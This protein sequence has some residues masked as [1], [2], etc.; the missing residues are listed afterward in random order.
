MS[1]IARFLPGLAVFA[2]VSST[3]SSLLACLVILAVC[4]ISA[5]ETFL[6][7]AF[8][9]LSY[10]S[11]SCTNPVI[12]AFLASVSASIPLRLAVRPV[13][14]KALK[15]S[16]TCLPPPSEFAPR[17]ACLLTASKETALPFS[18]SSVRFILNSD[19]F[20]ESS[21][22]LLS[23]TRVVFANASKLFFN[24]IAL[25]ASANPFSAPTT[26]PRP[27]PIRAPQGPNILP[28]SNPAIDPVA[29]P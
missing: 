23:T 1:S 17:F 16:R 7:L 21:S 14:S 19:E 26:A 15:N 5:V 4:S 11:S 10:A 24:V 3:E 13:G 28:I 9:N 18:A 25:A 8:P 22:K 27:A 2:S 6:I 20:L 29:A 12:K